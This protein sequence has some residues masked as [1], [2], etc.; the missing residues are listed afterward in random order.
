MEKRTAIKIDLIKLCGY[1]LKRCWL[2]ILCAMVGFFGMYWQASRNAVE[3]YTASGTMY[4]YNGN[5]NLVNY[6]YTSASDLNSAVRLLDTY[7]VVVRSNKVMDVVAERLSA[8]YPGITNA[9]IAGTL[10][11]GSVAETGVFRVS[12]TTMDAKMSYDICNAVL[13]AA[14]QALIDVVG[15]G[16]CNPLDYPVMPTVPNVTSPMRRAV[17]GAVGGA[18]LAGGLLLVLFL[19]NRKVTDAQELTDN[20]TPPVLSSIQR[21]KQDSEDPSVFLL[22]DQSPMETIESYAKLRMNLLYTLVDK[23]NRAVVVS[24]AISGEGKSTVAANLA[25]SCA[26]SG[27]RVLLIDGDLR[28]AC[29]RDNF[30]YKKEVAGLSEALIQS[31]KWQEVLLAT[32]WENL[33]I[34]PAGQLPPNP[35][36]LL[37]GERLRNVLD[38]IGKSFDLIL[39][40]TPPMNIVSDPLAL[41]DAVA[42]CLFIVRQNYS[43]HRDVRRALIAAEMTGM[44]VLGFAFYG[45]NVNQSS[46]YGSYYRRKYYKNYYHKYDNRPHTTAEN[47][48]TRAYA[49]PR[50][51]ASAQAKPKERVSYGRNQKVQA[52]V[53]S[54]SHSSNSRQR[55][56]GR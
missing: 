50:S 17:I 30:G 6:Q 34:L 43:D 53:R 45:E 25:I 48:E 4:V 33:L 41:S 18:V 37:S 5:P 13:D 28:R 15:A 20:Y 3:T 8:D 55:R 39:I 46:Y 10:T 23:D 54:A 56:S 24:S 22:N 47:A 29:Q 51:A 2:I 26:M 44:N 32:K 16:S 38:E 9:F 1:L 11:M 36:E 14:P 52:A 19:L 31:R 49:Q 7:M 35:A 42:G 40:D 12:C 21:V 27:K